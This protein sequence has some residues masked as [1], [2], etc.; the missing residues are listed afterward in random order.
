M[1]R[2]FDTDT[3]WNENLQKSL[4]FCSDRSP[5]IQNLTL[6]ALKYFRRRNDTAEIVHYLT[7]VIEYDPP[8]SAT[9]LVERG[10][11][12]LALEQFDNAVYDF[13]LVLGQGKKNERALVGVDR[14]YQLKKAA[15]RVGYYGVLNI[16]S[17]AGA[18]EIQAAYKKLVRNWHPDR[19]PEPA[20]KAKA[21]R[22]M[23][24]INTAY[25][26]LT[27]PEKKTLF[28]SGGDP[29]EL[30]EAKLAYQQYHQF[31]Q[32]YGVPPGF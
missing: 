11:A 17:Q 23:K 12:N 9:L 31:M 30:E 24:E 29:E 32:M 22:Q 16:T 7:K 2:V 6:A 21:E 10:E 5:L 19:F 15:R 14:A 8:N 18:N 28:D 26:I 20:E 27:D 1:R 4:Q 25:E 13:N 3:D